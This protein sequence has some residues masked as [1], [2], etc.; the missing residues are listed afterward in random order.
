MAAPAAR[1][2][3]QSGADSAKAK[4]DS[5]NKGRS[6]L[7][8][9]G[10]DLGLDVRLRAESRLE[11]LTNERCV[12]SQYFTL[13]SQ[14]RSGFQPLFDFKFKVRTGGT[15]ADRVHVN[16]DYDGAREF[17]G[18]NNISVYYEGK[19]N[20]WLQ[21][22]EV[23][24]VAF[25]TPA[26][27]F[28][29][30]GIPQGN[31]GLHALTQFGRLRLRGIIAEQKGYVVADRVYSVGARTREPLTRPIDDYQVEARRFFFV[32]DPRRLPGYPNI[33][34]LSGTRMR[35]LASSLPDSVRPSHVTLY[36]LLIGGQ[37]PNPNGPQ[38][39]INGDPFSRRGQVYEV[40]RE[41]VDYVVDPSQLWIA[42]AR[43]LNPNNER[44]VAAWTLRIGGRDTTVAST[45]G[46]P[47]VEYAAGREQF[48]N[49]LWDPQ[50]KPDDDAFAREIRSAYRVGG[51]DVR[52]ET[53]NVTVVSGGTGE[54]EKP[55][56]GPAQTFLQLFG[57]S[58]LSNASAFDA[59]NRLWPRPGDPI[60]S[61]GGAASAKV[62]R[63]LFLVFPSL[64]P[65]A[66]A[67]LAQPLQNPSNDAIYTT[68]GEYLY[69]P[70]HPQPVYAIRLR[71]ESDG[72]ADGATLALP[73]NQVRPF[74]ERL[75]LE[76]GTR[77]AR[78]TDYTVDY[79]VGLVTFLHADTLFVR[80]RNVS[81]R[82][83]EN[84]QSQ[85]GTAP[86]SILGIAS[87]LPFKYGELNLIGIAQQQ[88]S[89]FTRP[90]LGYEAQSSI[91][92]GLSGAFA[93]EVAPIARALRGLPGASPHATARLRVEA[94]LAASLPQ[95]GGSAPAYLESF[96]RD[97][98]IALSLADPNWSY[99][100]QPALGQRLGARIGGA[101]TLDISRAT[102]LAWQSNVVTPASL[103][104]VKI[105]L[106]QID[107]Q[108]TITGTG[109][110]QPEPL[111]WLTLYPLSI[112]G[113]LNSQTGTYQWQ[114]AGAPPGRRW[115]SLVQSFG[116]SG[117][118]LSAASY[119]QF[120]ALVDTAVARRTHNPVFVIDLGDV[121]E[122]SVAL[123][124]TSLT[125]RRSGTAVD[126]SYA[127]RTQ[128]ARDTLQS[129]RDPF[130]RAFNQAVND[131]G[132]A[133]DV[134]SRLVF[135]GPD[136]SAVLRNFRMCARTNS[137]VAS[138][139][140]TRTNCTVGNLKL[141]E[142]DLDGD[143]VLNLDSSQREQE[144]ILR[145]VVDLSDPASFT[146][147]GGCMAS[148]GTLP[149]TAG[150]RSCWVLVRVPVA[151]PFEALNGGPSIRRVR[152]LRLTMVSGPQA[153]D[154]DFATVPIA[155]LR[156]TGAPWL[157][158]RD[159]ALT[160]AGGERT[161]IGNVI[162]SSIGT[163]DRDS[164]HGLVYDSPP[165]AVDQ[166][167]QRLTGLENTRL[168]I[169]ERSMR[170]MATA[171]GVYERA[172]AYYRFPEGARNF[173]Q[174]REVRLWARG[175]GSGW[176]ERG[177]L[178]FFI[179]IGRDANNF[180]LYRTPV[181]G[182]AGAA[183]WLPEVVVNFEK[184]RALRVKLQNSWAR[185]GSAFV[186]CTG[187][188]SALIVQSALPFAQVSNRY[189]ACA[190][191][192]MV[193]TTDPAVT[194]PNLAGVQELAAGIVRVD[195]LGN[196]AGRVI[197]GD[198]LEVWIDDIR[199][200]KVENTPGYAAQLGVDLQTDLGSVHFDYAHRDAR[201]RQ[202]TEVPTNLGGDDFN[203]V[204]T[205]RLD[206]FLPPAFGWALPLT[207]SHLSA[208]SQPLFVTR[209]DLAAGGID[210]LRSPR[211]ASTNLSLGIRRSTPLTTGWYAPIVNNL[212][213]N[214]GYNGANAQSEYQTGGS[215]LVSTGADYT[216]GGAPDTRPM[217]AWWDRTISALPAWLTN[218]EM[219]QALRDAQFRTEPAQ[220]RLSSN[221]AKGDDHRSSFF[222]P[223]AS[224]VDTG[225]TV[226]GLT[227]LWR[228]ASSL[229]IRPFDALSAR[230]ELSSLR[231]LR[232]FG[233][234]TLA[235]ATATSE[236]T[237]FLGRDGGL[238]RERVVSTTFAFAPSLHGW[239]RPRADFMTSYQMQRDPNA[240][241]LL[242][243]ED[244]TG[245]YRLPRRVY[246]VQSLATGAQVNLARLANGWVRD[247]A[248]IAA[249]DHVLLPIDFAWT[250]S[251]NSSFDGT[252]FTPGFAYQFGW[253]GENGY[254][255]VRGVLASNAGTTSQ[256]ALNGGARL[257][258]GLTL[259]LG[260]RRQST[261]NWLI[262]PDRSQAVVDGD[263]V[264][265]PDL[266]IRGTWRPRGLENLLTSVSAAAGYT[267]SH[268]RYVVP[269]Y[270]A[271]TTG[272][273]RTGRSERYPLGA[274]VQFA[275]QGAL[276]LAFNISSTFRTDSL[277]GSVADGSSHDVNA[278]LSRVF[279]LPTD[280][281]LR[282]NLRTRLAYQ[283]TGSS[284]YVANA[285]ATGARSRLAD[286]G[287]RAISLNA[288]TDVSEGVTFSLQSAH[289][290]TF[291]NNLN[292]RYT[293][294][295][296]SAVLQ[297]AFF[298]GEMK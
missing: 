258:L 226:A 28:I 267:L 248:R 198:S 202:L 11:K 120:W 49:L 157:V 257:P 159:H 246:G 154:N 241:Q 93:F 42:L 76:D 100:S 127:G 103:G 167:D 48:A 284:E 34:I 218:T 10:S 169:N 33:D 135:S 199:L 148:P 293:Q 8:G 282:S 252:P 115:R 160:G 121:S 117:K 179:K 72:G 176:G 21:R 236:R 116:T 250:R 62:I 65:F 149:G 16:V 209:S 223:S 25:E 137:R 178:Q 22:L 15:V 259:G 90:Q 228:N 71:Y 181:S 43:P 114:V 78:G 172:E 273:V 152:A 227:S 150:N 184:L 66:R 271:G 61:V 4:A 45:G 192:Y 97:G 291:D 125:V 147:V 88:K 89:T 27:R 247:S 60:L 164:T 86:T 268:Q 180:Y 1:A 95:P 75:T 23:G 253:A 133:G 289:I 68:P 39:R 240:R 201:F 290:V 294:V 233:D 47:D 208:V 214:A 161:A 256:V 288:D 80:P 51:E 46:T 77:L 132:I 219:I 102:T 237:P 91:L 79:D 182:A 276:A 94:E 63:D 204:T 26:S 217:P 162:A 140:D 41:N 44:L 70:Q 123:G 153:V 128:L 232:Q 52:R 81:V 222:A 191:G 255:D 165:G 263:Q 53:V 275:E 40:L 99:S 82:Y 73:T 287:R 126:S 110:A 113:S 7:F 64:Q 173:L 3:A 129:E 5:A 200:A 168:V 261:R 171:L 224:T 295:V 297:I 58:Q 195:S 213:L 262:R 205:L 18:S 69:S 177:E 106:E 269:S 285:F 221:Y 138:L 146:R 32:V 19:R 136:S 183:A 186:G 286:N 296:L 260:T 13:A 188:D 281:K 104:G 251:R 57:L 203:L 118:D 265:L 98:G 105:T 96:E 185:S 266:S 112:G 83:E 155:Q 37:P 55:L 151:A 166:A 242:R 249:I 24:N 174:Y 67:G 38:F 244:S 239:F 9:P 56:A 197:P 235:A 175:R 92:T 270:A 17:E 85:L 143:N 190:D 206:R 6:D 124:P 144:R 87:T 211:T 189:A 156:L 272:D 158:R 194:P 31:Y 193:Y 220:L 111:L 283:S 12:S 142:W 109:V 216:L 54:Q 30:R 107:P 131:N 163:Q 122:N 254:R 210:G 278:E 84:P 292:R 74:S 14:C 207:L 230:W 231:D 229:E 215:S 134:V 274:S 145:Y 108:L 139:G 2:T 225:R 280:W 187:A 170:L 298:A 141:D 35:Q 234:T 29:T 130:S 245:A 279:R 101:A 212:S 50:V 59:D 119:L 36:R 277:P 264:T 243:E 20:D 238:E 196:G